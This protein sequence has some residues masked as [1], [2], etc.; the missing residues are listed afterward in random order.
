MSNEKPILFNT[1]M[2]KAILVDKKTMTRRIIKP[3]PRFKLIYGNNVQGKPVWREY[4]EEPLADPN[5]GS[6]LGYRHRCPW[7][8]GDILWVRETF[9][10]DDFD[11]G[12]KNVY[13]KADYT[14][15]EVKELFTDLDMK[16]KPS[17]HMP[18]TAA[19][20]FLEVKGIRVERLQDITEEDA[21]DEGIVWTDEGPLHAHYLNHDL[22]A[23]LN[24]KTPKEAFSSLWD[25]IYAERGNG[26]DVNPFVWVVEF[27]RIEG[28]NSN[29]L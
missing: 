28:V 1:E 3:Q 15:K 18:R 8:V 10:Y 5:I 6:P 11:D 9:C 7:Q 19:R 14:E 23:S 29:G 2:V 25:S 4:S 26:W 13:H 16:W 24:F 21:I 20:L 22:N 27:E 17:I 12:E